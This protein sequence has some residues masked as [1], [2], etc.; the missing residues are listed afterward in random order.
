MG[1]ERP[2]TIGRIDYANAWP[3]F[4]QLEA[5]LAQRDADAMHIM[6]GVPSALNRALRQG[7]ADL[8]AVS[9]FAY[10]QLSEELVLLPDLS[11]SADGEVMSILLFLKKPLEEVLRG[12][13][14]VT[15]TSATSVNLLRI[16]MHGRFEAS[17]HYVAMEPD[18]DAM[19]READA[20][21]L[22][23]DPAIR[24][25][26]RSD[27][28]CEILDVARLWKDWTG[29]GMTFAVVAVREAAVR[30]APA[31]VRI[32]AQALNDSKRLAL[33]G[34]DRLAAKAAASIGG[35]LAYWSRYFRCIKY[36]FGQREREGLALY[37]RYA[38][39]L[40]LLTHEVKL[41]FWSDHTVAQVNE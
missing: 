16:I 28:G 13:I 36:G 30:Q 32:V 34:I 14:A 21:L 25:S 7:D 35:E 5:C 9:S 39:Q 41:R 38:Y 11:V 37:F 23:G 4:D 17:P 19:L 8:A 6:T 2:I 10:G 12:T 20:A 29:L 27:H 3:L 40:G 22:I 26:W 33:A 15:N 1:Y 31:A 24:A 18:L